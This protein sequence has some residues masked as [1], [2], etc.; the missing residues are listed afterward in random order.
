MEEHLASLQE[1]ACVKR[2]A[3]EA[4]TYLTATLC[5]AIDRSEDSLPR[6]IPFAERQTRMDTLKQG[7][8]GLSVTG[9]HEP[10]H[11]LLPCLCDVRSKHP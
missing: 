8:T 4:Q 9:G 5:Q 1:T 11:C 7:L 2:A 10:A 6:K 3:F